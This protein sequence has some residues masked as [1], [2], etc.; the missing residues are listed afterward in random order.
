MT[1]RV[2]QTSPPLAQ[3][4]GPLD[5]LLDEV[6]RQNVAVENIAMAPLVARFLQYM[7]SGVELNLNLDIE[8]LHMAATLIQ[9]KSRSLL[10]KDAAEQPKA[11]LIRDDLVQQLL[12]H[13]KQAA[14][15]LD[16]RRSLEETR[17][18][19]PAVGDPAL[20]GPTGSLFSAWDM[21][22]Q[23]RELGRWVQEH[24]IVRRQWGEAFGVE[25]DDVTISEM[26]AY[27]REQ[28]DRRGVAE[29]DG[30]S[31]LRDQPSATHR[32]CL[33]LGMLEMVR[34]QDVQLEQT[35]EFGPIRLNLCV[36]GANR[37]QS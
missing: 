35:E 12:A 30:G 11:D 36:P 29:L 20:D 2:S 17:F 33:F 37:D 16:D 1:I 28:F 34:D 25:E 3:F 6:R 13:R 21:I 19:R 24:R 18:S 10:P 32:C 26:M 15:A 5:L 8:W 9:W 4:E 14:A 22:Q 31:L 27:L 7:R 23:A